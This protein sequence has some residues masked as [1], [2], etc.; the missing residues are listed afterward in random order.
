MTRWFY[1]KVA[2]LRTCSLFPILSALSDSLDMLWLDFLVVVL[3]N[4]S[5]AFTWS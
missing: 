4:L 3:A 1:S 5:T 2:Y